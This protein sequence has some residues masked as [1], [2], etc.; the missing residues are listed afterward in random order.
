MSS[1]EVQRLATDGP[2]AFEAERDA[3]G[4]AGFVRVPVGAALRDPG[5]DGAQ[6]DEPVPP[7]PEEIRQAAYDEGLAAGRAELPWQEAEALRGVVERLERALESIEGLRRDCVVSARETSV[8]LAIAIAERLVRRELAL[9]P[10]PLLEIVGRALE[11]LPEEK[12]LRIELASEDVAL[13][14]QG[15]ASELESLTAST[16]AIIDASPELR[17]G[18]VRVL[19][20]HG[21]VDARIPTLLG[22]VREGLEGLFDMST[23]DGTAEASEEAEESEATGEEEPG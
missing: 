17:A 21:A 13:L 23:D 4:G 10:A 3:Q 14:Q 9:D 5:A 2:E 20:E 12:K 7:T 19:G 16:G 8:E 11:A 18:D 1:F 22:R 6:D 15:L